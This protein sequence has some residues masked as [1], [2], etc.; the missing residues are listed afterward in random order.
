ML[1]LSSARLNSSYVA[2]LTL[3]M[4]GAALT[5]SSVQLDHSA[6]DNRDKF[7]NNPSEL[8]KVEDSQDARIA[9]E[10]TRMK[11]WEQSVI[12]HENTHMQVGGEFAGAP[13]YI[14]QKGPDGKL[15]I[16]G[17]EVTMKLPAG[18]D[19][20]KLKAALERVKRAA[21]APAD[22]S[23][24][25]QKTA[26]MASA[27]QSSVENA[28]KRK[29]AAEAYEKQKDPVHGRGQTLPTDDIKHEIE[30]FRKLIF[31]EMSRF[32]MFA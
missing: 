3:S 5:T 24:Q 11:N 29:K 10:L 31:E 2:Q 15:H 7:T 6:R 18:G 19:L 9:H 4:K 21:M 1:T 30:P 25:D 26:A 20:E 16:V 27:Q 14:Y 17:G 22:P 32:E 13:S 12:S 28:I 8:V 23:P